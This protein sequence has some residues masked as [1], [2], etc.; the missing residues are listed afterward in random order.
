MDILRGIFGLAFLTAV[1]FALSANR[2]SIPWTTVGAGIL[3]Q[4]VFGLA[5]FKLGFV[6][7]GFE[8]IS[9]KFVTFLD[10]AR[11]G[12]MFLFGGLS[13]DSTKDPTA[14]HSLGFLFASQALPTVIFFSAVTTGLYYLGILQKIVYVFA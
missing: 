3:L 13:K 11:Q 4:V 10:F 7:D 2:K 5:I 8:W 6:H 12:A 14:G 1:A 9:E